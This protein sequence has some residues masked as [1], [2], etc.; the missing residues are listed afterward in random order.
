MTKFMFPYQ[1]E[2]ASTKKDPEPEN[3]PVITTRRMTRSQ[4]STPAA[5]S[6][7]KKPP[8]RGQT[9]SATA[10]SPVSTRSRKR[11]S[12]PDGDAKDPESPKKVATKRTSP[13]VAAKSAER[14]ESEEIQI[15][16][17]TEKLDQQQD[18]PTSP[19][20]SKSD[21]KTS[22]VDDT[23]PK[24][25]SKEDKMSVSLSS[26]DSPEPPD[27]DVIMRSPNKKGGRRPAL[28]DTDSDEEKKGEEPTGNDVV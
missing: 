28:F 18:R 3:T 17:K 27:D 19:V 15:R 25:T 1:N 8:T 16:S 20:H 10:K 9:R 13:R 21:E 23:S 11:S 26:N 22:G 6:T 5:A 7:S 2:E 14:S 24:A 12:G 4:M